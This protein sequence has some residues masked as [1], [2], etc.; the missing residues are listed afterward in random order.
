[1]LQRNLKGSLKRQLTRFKLVMQ[2]KYFVTFHT[3]KGT[4]CTSQI[5]DRDIYVELN[6]SVSPVQALFFSMTSEARLKSEAK[7]RKKPLSQCARGCLIK[8]TDMLCI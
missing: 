2:D 8:Y 7:Q 1:M 3:S 6:R 4:I 5:E